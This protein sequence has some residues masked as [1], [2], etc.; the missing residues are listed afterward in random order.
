MQSHAF[1]HIMDA[2]DIETFLVCDSEEEGKELALLLMKDMGF[3]DVDI[4]FIKFQGAGVRVRIRAYI[5]RAGDRYPWLN[6]KTHGGLE[7]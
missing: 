1:A 6:L 7:I 5:Y 3:E 2:L 4:V